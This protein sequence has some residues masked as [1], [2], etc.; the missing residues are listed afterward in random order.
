MADLNSV[1]LIGRLTRQAE[2]RYSQAGGG[3]V[4]RF[5]IAVNRRKRS[6]DGSGWEDEANFF[7][8]V[9]FGRSAE[10]INQYLEKGRQVSI[11]GELRQ[12]RWEQDGASRSRV[13]IVVNQLNL[14]GGARQDGSPQGGGQFTSAPQQGQGG[15]S[16]GSS[17]LVISLTD[18][19]GATGKRLEYYCEAADT[20]ALSGHP[21]TVMQMDYRI[22]NGDLLLTGDAGESWV[23]TG[24][25]SQQVSETTDT[26][27]RGGS[28]FEDSYFA[29]GNGVYAVFYGE[30]PTLHLS[31]DKGATWQDIPFT[32][33][34]PRLCTRRIVRFLDSE[35]GYAGLG[36]DWTM[37]SGGA[38]YVYWTHDG[39]ETWT[40]STELYEEAMMLDGL[41][42]SDTSHGVVSLQTVNGDEQY[43]ALRVTTDGG[44]SFTELVLPW[45][46]LPS[47]VS[48]LDKVDSLTA[49]GGVFTLTLGQGTAGNTKAVFTSTDL[50]QGWTFKDSFQGTIHTEG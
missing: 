37:G 33:Y 19:T 11:V 42:F 36:T 3:A 23:S 21:E 15:V 32:D 8:C 28:L 7:D 1:C 27:Q 12:S 44:A 17:A 43:P 25:S 29:D 30:R 9:F 13:E 5:S 46:S 40:S 14:I 4:V 2:I 35:N 10:S 22:N 18:G 6:A 47:S 16:D 41:A 24:L 26:Y 31:R 39:G 38:T 45:E 20:S 50:T 48:F 49:E 34:M